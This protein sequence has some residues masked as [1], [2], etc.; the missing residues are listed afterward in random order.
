M[1]IS[2]LLQPT[3][4]KANYVV[5]LHLQYIILTLGSEIC[6]VLLA[7]LK[8]EDVLWSL[9]RC[10]IY[11]ALF[12][13]GMRIRARISR[14]EASD[15][16]DFLS[17]SVIKNGLF[18]GVGQLVF[19]ALSSVQCENEKSL[20]GESWYECKRSLYS[21]TG[22]G[23]QVGVAT[24]VLLL[25][26]IVPSKYLDR[27]VLKVEK[28]VAMD[29]T[30]DEIVQVICLTI[31][32]GCG[33]FLL[34]NYG[35][36]GD[37]SNDA[38]EFFFAAVTVTGCV[39]VV[40]TAVW[41]AVVIHSE[42]ISDEKAG[43][44]PE[45][46][47]TLTGEPLTELSMFW[48]G[49]GALA[50]SLFTGLNIASAVINSRIT[51]IVSISSA[52]VVIVVF[53]I[54]VFAQPRKHDRLTMNLLRAYF[55]IF[56]G[57]SEGVLGARAISR[58]NFKWTVIHAVRLAIDAVL[59]HYGLRARAAIGRLSDSE[60][61]EFLTCHLF[62]GGFKMLAPILFIVFR[63]L[64]CFI[65]R[66][67]ESRCRNSNACALS[68][69]SYLII[70]WFLGLAQGSIKKEWRDQLDLSIEKVV[71]M[72]IS[73]RKSIEGILLAVMVACGA[74]LFALMTS[75][76]HTSGL[77]MTVSFAGL[78]AGIACFVSEVYTVTKE[79]VR[80][81]SS[82]T[83]LERADPTR[84]VER[85][86][87]CS[88]WYVGAAFVLTSSY[89]L[90]QLTYAIVLDDGLLM[91]GYMLLPI[92]GG[93]MVISGYLRPKDEGLG[94]K[95]LHAQ[96]F[97]FGVLAAVLSCIAY[98][99]QGQTLLALA[100]L[101]RI[102]IWLVFY[103]LGLKL[104]RKA[105]Q[106]QPSELSDFLCR[107]VLLGGI[108]GMAPMV[109]FGFEALSCITSNGGLTDDSCKNTSYAA[110]FLSVY[111]A[112]IT[113]VSMSSKVISRA[114][115]GAALTY[116]QVATLKL[117][118]SQKLQGYCG[119]FAAIASMYL[120]S[121]LGVQGK[122]NKAITYLGGAGFFA[123]AFSSL[124]EGYKLSRSTSPGGSGELS[125]TTTTIMPPANQTEMVQT[126][127]RNGLIM[128]GGLM[129]E[130][131]LSLGGIGDNMVVAGMV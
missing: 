45:S 57:I 69:S 73:W 43:R 130:R 100:T 31:A 36:K 112:M 44:E 95:I 53:V 10:V 61:H 103:W 37:F 122:P 56:A 54:S 114:E 40:V 91:V 21:Q 62:V 85:V 81:R 89:T 19:L 72:K 131:R 39:A 12:P 102:P 46:T 18:V 127:S 115:R 97:L 47:R 29:L 32:G 68:I 9:L 79:Q 82:D 49:L 67:A 30:V 15:L 87:C 126:N 14:L 24:I 113:V 107:K 4:T 121:V 8:L 109:F 58:G 116:E 64:K 6:I 17:L 119:V 83:Q 59:F 99:R 3:N 70:W 96:F 76:Q 74:F 94:K 55:F 106:L 50:A 88:W 120:F 20:E 28:I 98:L 5:F 66:E 41:K 77:V 60:L 101:G 16:S 48:V 11:T 38:E 125:T 110:L 104:R 27:H 42:V 26:G 35:V 93:C 84:A 7:K 33:L 34:G 1:V 63:S 23:F 105:A 52:P 22:L 128:A 111:V 92:A 90:L 51:K 71:T 75:K 123:L 86:D 65:E 13:I 108:S 124:I 25:S 78:I 118:R 117:S 80:N 129:S 2:F